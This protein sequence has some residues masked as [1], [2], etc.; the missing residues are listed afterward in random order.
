M[1]RQYWEVFHEALP[2]N[3]YLYVFKTNFLVEKWLVLLIGIKVQ[4]WICFWKGAI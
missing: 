1:Q 2:K 4:I 3:G